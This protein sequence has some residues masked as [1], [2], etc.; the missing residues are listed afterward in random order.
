MELSADEFFSGH[1]SD[2][3]I[4]LHD[5]N[6]DIGGGT[7]SIQDIDELARHPE[8][9]C[10]VISGL[11]Q[12]TF[13]YFIRTYGPQL[14]AIHFHKNKLVEDW[15]LLG[16]LP[17]LEYVYWFANQRIDRLWDLR[18]NRSLKGLL[19]S[20]FSRLHSIKGI[21]KAGALRYFSIGNAIWLTMVVDSLMPLAGTAITDLE[22]CGRKIAD[23]NLAFFSSLRDLK[24]FNC[25]L[26]LLPTEQFAWIAAN[27]PQVEGRALHPKEDGTVYITRDGKNLEVPGAYIIGKRKPA[28]PCAGN[29]ARI[30]R[31]VES[32][33]RMKEQYRGMTFEEAFPVL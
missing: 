12:D 25:A 10:V 8:A 24:S 1:F 18:E 2:H 17:Q 31:Y 30:Q 21:E 15:S 13:A 14:K 32:F 33:E 5:P 26:N 23:G 11:R 6:W 3:S 22:F 9:E 16:T 28:L 19:I 4:H 27:F 20:D 7:I 29:E